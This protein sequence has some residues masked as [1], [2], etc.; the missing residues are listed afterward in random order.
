MGD[1]WGKETLCSTPFGIRG[2]FTGAVLTGFGVSLKVCS[3]PFGIRGRFTP[4]R[5]ASSNY[6]I[7]SAQRLSASEV[8][9]RPRPDHLEPLRRGA[10]LNAFRHQR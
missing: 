9:S 6:S 10:V 4:T 8:G 7:Q 2:R 3:T 5:H 1:L